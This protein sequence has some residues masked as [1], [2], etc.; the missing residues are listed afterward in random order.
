ML[1]ALCGGFALRAEPTRTATF[2]TNTIAGE[3]AEPMSEETQALVLRGAF[4]GLS[5]VVPKLRG[6]EVSFN[7]KLERVLNWA[8][9]HHVIPAAITVGVLG[10]KTLGYGPNAGVNAGMEANFYLS[11]GKLMSTTYELRGVQGGYGMPVF[12]VEFYV[13]LCFGESCYG[14]NPNGWYLGVDANLEAGV[15]IQYTLDAPTLIEAIHRARQGGRK[16]DRQDFR[17]AQ[18]FSVGVGVDIGIDAEAGLGIYHYHQLGPELTLSEPGQTTTPAFI[19]Q[20]LSAYAS[21]VSTPA[22]KN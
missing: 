7:R 6:H 11:H 15:F 1:V 8:N 18:T 16:L 22:D 9:A 2:E 10:R 13:A 17:D 12:D 21:K 19:A 3:A 14:G 5:K 4:M 20:Q